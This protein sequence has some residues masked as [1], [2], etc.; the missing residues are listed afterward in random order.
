[1]SGSNA[2]VRRV[3]ERAS[4]DG[5]FR[6]LLISD[7][8]TAVESELG[9]IIPADLT[10]KVFEEGPDEFFIVLPPMEACDESRDPA[11]AAAVAG[12]AGAAGVVGVSGVVGGDPFAWS[13]SHLG[14]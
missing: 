11:L 9:V 8:K 12:V 1:M 5:T 4:T 14:R 6:S 10:V 7:P 2:L 3:V 13:P